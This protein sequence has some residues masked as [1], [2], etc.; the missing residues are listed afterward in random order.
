[1][2][3]FNITSPGALYR[4]IELKLG[5]IVPELKG[6]Q[7][8]K[9]RSSSLEIKRCGDRGVEKETYVNLREFGYITTNVQL[10]QLI[11]LMH[12]PYFRDIF[13]R[14]ILSTGGVYQNKSGIIN[15][16]NAD[17]SGYILGIYWILNIVLFTLT[18][19]QSS[20][21]EGIS[22]LFRCNANR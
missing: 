16:D 18:F 21:I 17:E 20:I 9:R 2:Q 15:L 1:L 14:T 8:T 22:T 6:E 7:T 10:Q 11:K 5:I 3:S 12:I 4:I 13:M 19:W